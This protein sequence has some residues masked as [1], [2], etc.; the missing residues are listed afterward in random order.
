MPTNDDQRPSNV[1]TSL[2]TLRETL[3]NFNTQEREER[4]Q[5]PVNCTNNASM[6]S[7]IEQL[8]SE[9]ELDTCS[10]E[11]DDP[12]IKD[13]NEMIAEEEVI[14]APEPTSSHAN[15]IHETTRVGLALIFQATNE[16]EL[17]SKF[18]VPPQNQKVF[19]HELTK[20]AMDCCW[21]EHGIPLFTVN[22]T[23]L[24][25][26]EDWKIMGRYPWKSS[27]KML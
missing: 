25:I 22:N 26:L 16:L 27:N 12:I 6:T 1:T 14:M 5:H 24:N 19:P 15:E 2:R 23:Q 9:N 18:D 11:S 7:Y 17:D 3:I 13:T 20:R 21:E 8:P 10:I 4:A